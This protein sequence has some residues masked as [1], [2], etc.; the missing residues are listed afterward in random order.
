MQLPF[1]ATSALFK[2]KRKINCL[3]LIFRNFLYFIKRKFSLHFGKWKPRKNSLYFRKR[4]FFISHETSYISGSNFPNSKN[5][6][7]NSKKLLIKKLLL[8]KLLI[9]REMELS[10]PKLRKLLIFQER[11]LKSRSKIFFY[12]LE[13]FKNKFI[14]F[15]S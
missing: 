12:F 3:A 7:K 15:S 5:K 2:P 9:F 10:S 13:V 4:N 1:A 6:K 8:K 11:T 14:H